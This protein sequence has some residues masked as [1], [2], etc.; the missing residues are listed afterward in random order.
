VLVGRFLI[1]VGSCIAK[2]GK[3]VDT[4]CWMGF[5]PEMISS[6]DLDYYLSPQFFLYSLK[7]PIDEPYKSRD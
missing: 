7:L 2:I 6:F 3:E 5:N 1:D 4:G